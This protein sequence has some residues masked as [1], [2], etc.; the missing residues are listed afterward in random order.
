MKL[1]LKPSLAPAFT[2]IEMVGVL[3]VIALLGSLL[4]PK[5]FAAIEN[6]RLNQTVGSLNSL[7]MASVE[8]YVAYGRFGGLGGGPL[9]T[10]TNHWDSVLIAE[11]RL[12]APFDT[13]MGNNP[14]VKVVRVPADTRAGANGCFN[15]SGMRGDE[16]PEGSVV[17]LVSIEDVTANDA[18]ALSERIDGK[19]LSAVD[20]SAKDTLGR[21]TY[22]AGGGTV[23]LYVCH[24]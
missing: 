19:D 12:D 11:G 15:L 13:R 8:Y 4:V 17:V 18:L 9:G 1:I 3:A 21:V 22:A 5:V 6:A 23:T 24:R 16:L 10:A 7:R 20:A 2:L 14:V